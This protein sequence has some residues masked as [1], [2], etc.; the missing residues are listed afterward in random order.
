MNPPSPRS[1]IR[2]RAMI[3]HTTGRHSWREVPDGAVLQEDGTIVAVG[4]FADLARQHPDVTVIG[5]GNEIMLPGFVNGHHHVGLTPLQL[6]SP[7]MPLELWFVTR[8]VARN[9]DPYLDTLYS[10]FEMIASGVTTVQHIHGWAPGG[11]REVEARS[12][13]LLRAYDDVGMRVSYCYAVREQNRLVYQRDEDFVAGL[14]GELRGPMQR[15]FDRFQMTLDDHIALFQNLHGRYQTRSRA[16]IQ[17]APANLHWCSDA[18]LARLADT[19]RQYDVPLH[20]HLLET[21]YQKEYA[22]R[23]SG[24]GTAVDHLERFGL[25]GPRMTLGH[26]AWLNEHDI[27]RLAET[28]TCVCHNCSSNFRLRSGV[29]PLNA[30]EAR[31][32]TT[33]IGLDEAGINDDRDM[34]QE[35]RMVLRAHRVPGMRDDDVPTP[36]QV[37]R[38]ATEGGALTTPFGDHL[39]TLAPGKAADMVLIDWQQIAYPYLDETMPLLDAVMQR[40]RTRGVRTVICDGA[41]IYA[42][43]RFTRVDR[44]AALR[45]LHDDLTKALADDEV[46][47]RKLSKALLP[48]VKAFYDGYYDAGAHVPFY[49]PSSRV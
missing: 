49:K 20:M 14:P 40:A 19:S 8:M 46:E 43:G 1:L 25:L 17:L 30:L 28:G 35:M 16:K 10:A 45:A 23:R 29:A 41:V 11:L 32:V 33:A 42:D 21:A 48:H 3:T 13:A 4:T 12:D 22:R 5:T 38:M 15:W 36:A 26:G 9:V 47:R 7:D 37:L 34:L 2:S 27:D 24:G 31:G 18:A 39:G 6:G 44:D